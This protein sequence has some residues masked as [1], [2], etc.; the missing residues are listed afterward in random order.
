MIRNQRNFAQLMA[1]NTR[2]FVYL[3]HVV[4]VI[5]IERFSRHLAGHIGVVFDNILG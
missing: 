3:V 5:W 1:E 2:P 4:W